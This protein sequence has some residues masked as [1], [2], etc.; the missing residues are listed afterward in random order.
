MRISHIAFLSAAPALML[1][2]C[3]EKQVAPPVEKDK[4]MVARAQLKDVD[5]KDVGEAIVAQG[6]TGL[7]VMVDSTAMPQGTHGVHIHM[8]GTCDSPDFKSA[9]GH[10]NPTNAQHGLENPAGPHYG[11]LPN[12]TVNKDG[13][14][15][16]EANVK[17]AVLQNGENALMDTDG[18]AFIVHKGADDQKTD[19]SG[20]SGDRIACGVFQ[21]SQG[22]AK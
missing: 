17:G 13:R 7:L 19:P 18:A 8:T 14:G 16:L 21:I 11:D 3:Q 4:S 6:D 22:G 15:T 10:W 5:G 12:L 1:A 20:D 9:G 2:A